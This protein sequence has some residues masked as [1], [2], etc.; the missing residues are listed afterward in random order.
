MDYLDLKRKRKPRVSL[1]NNQAMELWKQGKA[2]KE[3]AIA[4]DVSLNSVRN[5]RHRNKLPINKADGTRVSH[6]PKKK[7]KYLTPLEKDAIAARQAGMT[8][9]EYKAQQREYGK[10]QKEKSES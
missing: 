6:Y 10:K 1:D 2:D 9:G 8:Y 5:F 3:I 4:L 7:E